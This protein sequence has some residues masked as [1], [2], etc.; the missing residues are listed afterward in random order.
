[1]DLYYS[2]TFTF[3]LAATF[4]CLSDFCFVKVQNTMGKTQ[5]RFF[6]LLLWIVALNGICTTLSGYYTLYANESPLALYIIEQSRYFYFVIHSALA[7]VFFFYISHVCGVVFRANSNKKKYIYYAILIICEALAITN[8]FTH[9]VYYHDAANNHVFTRNWGEAIIYIASGF[10]LFLSFKYLYTSWGALNTKRRSGLLMFLG[11]TL[12]GILAQLI[13]SDLKVELFAEAIGL[14]G[15]M[16]VI[17]NEDDR[18]DTETGL[19]NRQAFILDL[20]GYFANKT[21]LHAIS[22]R[23]ETP[24]II[25]RKSGVANRE[26]AEKRVAEYLETIHKKYNI[27]KLGRRTFVLVAFGLTDDEAYDIASRIHL[28]F[29]KPWQ[30]VDTLV[31]LESSL[32]VAKIPDQIESL[33][34]ALYMFESFQPGDNSKKILSGSDLDFILRGSA[35]EK[36]ISN[37]L[38]D[39]KFEVFYQ[40]TY[41]IDGKTLHG[42][43]A[44]VRLRDDEMGMLYPDEFIPVAENIGL[45]DAID[46]FVLMEVCKMIKAEKLDEI[47][48]CINVNLSVIQLMKPGFV[49]HINGIV[50]M[51]GVDK[52]FINFEVTESISAASYELMNSTINSLK[53]EGFLF[54]M[55]DYG[56][57]YSNMKALASM[58]LDCIKIDKSILWEAEK[59]ELGYI[60]LENCVRMIHQMNLDILVEGVE[61]AEQIELLR[62]LGVNYLQGYYFSRPVPKDNFLMIVRENDTRSRA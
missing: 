1:M 44:L 62:P 60:I 45:I 20:G 16:M 27:Y 48:D 36:A 55:D 23:I 26:L 52:K 2:L 6:V 58:H 5:N 43:E 28:R 57:G 12:A 3:S 22:L 14:T 38:A 33:N 50:E 30:L 41:S 9:W 42:A 54:S 8:P 13:N 61:T 35:I 53:D 7:P 49:E 29:D 4:I 21:A 24:E 32:L 46:D 31:L 39:G 47:V 40:P 18:I 10:F 25:S 37:G 11:I 17:E 51:S 56:T 19:Y 15:V 59:S 34:D